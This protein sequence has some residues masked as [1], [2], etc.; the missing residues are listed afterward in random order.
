MDME[1]HEEKLHNMIKI[2]KMES[3][4]DQARDAAKSIRD[5][6]REQ[7]RLGLG[8]GMTGIGGGNS[9]MSSTTEITPNVTSKKSFC[10]LLHQ[11]IS[12]L[13]LFLF[14]RYSTN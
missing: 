1:S 14:H 2:S 12:S 10:S 7:Q 6:Q 8:S 11:M 4:K 9:Q 3:A 13:T 5:R